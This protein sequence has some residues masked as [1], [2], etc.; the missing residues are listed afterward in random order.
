MFISEIH[1][2]KSRFFG[3]GV[4]AAATLLSACDSDDSNPLP[5]PS[6]TDVTPLRVVHAVADAPTV[7]VISGGASLA[8]GVAFKDATGNI[9]APVGTLAVQVDADVPGGT[10]TV[11]PETNLQIESDTDYTVIAAGEAANGTI[12]PIVL[13]NPVAP[14]G[15]GNV[16]VEV[17]HAAPNANNTDAND[18]VDIYVTAPGTA[19][20]NETP[21]A[22]GATPFGANSGQLEVPGS[23]YQIRATAPGG[24]T[25]VFDSGTV[26]L[27]W[28]RST[29]QAPVRR[30]LRSSCPML[31]AASRF[32]M[33]Q[34]RRRS[35]SCT[36]CPM[37]PLSTYTSTMQWR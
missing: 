31:Q 30:R 4:L 2:M 11:I 10:V 24:M 21:I 33:R 17:V 29:T 16:R 3:F 32:S 13:A 6:V 22:G 1:K 14:I 9:P 12:A 35:V 18:A 23:D 15:A 8:S 25:P 28:S 19:L 27:S 37:R 36:P 5:L 7:S 26:T 20:M 34:R